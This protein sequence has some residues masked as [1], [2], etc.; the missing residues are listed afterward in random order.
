MKLFKKKQLKPPDEPETLASMTN[1]QM[2]ENI[3][4]CLRLHVTNYSWDASCACKE[5]FSNLRDADQKKELM[6]IT[7]IVR[8]F[9]ELCDSLI[10]KDY[11]SVHLI[12]ALAFCLSAMQDTMSAMDTWVRITKAGSFK[13]ASNMMYQVAQLQETGTTEEPPKANE[14][15]TKVFD[16]EKIGYG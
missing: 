2:S 10:T 12:L 14:D 1:E 4:N 13:E 5:Y 6:K 7:E 15:A 3:A 16:R 11:N 9:Q 8:E